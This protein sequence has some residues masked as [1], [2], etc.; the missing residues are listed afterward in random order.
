MGPA[1]L[2]RAG[3]CTAE[4]QHAKVLCRSGLPKCAGGLQCRSTG[5]ES[6][7]VSS[8]MDVLCGG[9]A[10]NQVA[11]PNEQLASTAAI[12]APCHLSERVCATRHNVCGARLAGRTDVE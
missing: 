3:A 8:E 2:R 10:G 5:C 4:E 9:A 1:T 7:F 12:H 6:C 11:Y